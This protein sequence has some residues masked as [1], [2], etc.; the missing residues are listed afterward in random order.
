MTAPSTSRRHSIDRTPQRRNA[1]GGTL[2]GIFIG[3]VVGL[4]MAA[5][6]AYWLMKNNP[7]LPM[8]SLS[9]DVHE[10]SREAANVA[11]ADDK[12][13]FDFYKIL[14][15]VEEPKVQP[16]PGPEHGDRAV[17]EQAK[18]RAGDPPGNRTST[19]SSPPVQKVATAVDSTAKVLKL[20]DRF[21][22]QAGS[23]STAPDA[24]NLRARLALSGWE[25]TVQE[26]ALPDKGIRYRVRLGPYDNADELGRMK[27]EL[28]KR[29]FDVAVI[30]Y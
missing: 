22:L 14:P 30:R 26:G 8:P 3:L 25:A 7:A 28:A 4:G 27:S 6:V 11:K 19:V 17:V 12:P 18:E 15:G 5:T 9:R 10:P 2:I 23:F 1:L 16:S 20:N 21:W 13:R 24:E 29:G